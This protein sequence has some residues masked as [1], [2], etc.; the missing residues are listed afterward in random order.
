M[1]WPT[2]RDR[3]LGEWHLPLI[4]SE[5]VHSPYTA[6]ENAAKY[7]LK[8]LS[9]TTLSAINPVRNYYFNAPEKGV[10]RRKECWYYKMKVP[11]NKIFV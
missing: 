6:V 4:V 3:V 7:K 9:K 10:A 1:R 11:A 5:P 8:M 2:V